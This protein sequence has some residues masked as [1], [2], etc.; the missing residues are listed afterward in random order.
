MLNPETDNQSRV[1]S[2]KDTN[3]ASDAV[4]LI[5]KQAG[6][7]ADEVASLAALDA[8]DRAAEHQFS[9]GAPALTSLFE[10]AKAADFYAGKFSPSPEVAKVM[11]ESLEFL[12]QRKRAGTLLDHDKMLFHDDTLSGLASIGFFGLAIP[13]E[14]GGSGA[15]L[16][17]L[18]PLLRALTFVHPDMGVMF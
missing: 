13:Q 1:E 16:G 5:L 17:D 2:G 18:G 8:A 9:G 11:A 14:Y 7:S 3:A 6:R 4:S 12:M 10:N 15:K